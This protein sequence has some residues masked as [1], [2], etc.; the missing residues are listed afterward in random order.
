M[1]S[2]EKTAEKL[3]ANMEAGSQTLQCLFP[4]GHSDT[5][6]K[7]VYV[8]LNNS[9]LKLFCGS[10]LR[11]GDFKESKLTLQI[12]T[13]LTSGKELFSYVQLIGTKPCRL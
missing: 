2:A 4:A 8:R 10:S 1:A 12:G 6:A 3:P 9:R 13:I 5:V 11:V 7:L